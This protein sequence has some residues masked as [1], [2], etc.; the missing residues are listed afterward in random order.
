MEKRGLVPG[1]EFD[2]RARLILAEIQKALMPDHASD[3]VCINVET[4]EYTLGATRREAEDAFGRRWPHNYY[5]Q[6][7]VDGGPAVKFHGM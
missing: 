5:F 2:R 4:G 6:I 7:R 1:R 3:I